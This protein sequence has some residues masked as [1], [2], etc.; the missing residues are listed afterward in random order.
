MYSQSIITKLRKLE[1]QKKLKQRQAIIEY[2]LKGGET[3]P[4]DPNASC[5]GEIDDEI[6]VL[7]VGH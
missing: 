2:M 4:R 5:D 6:T 1:R 7:K 3:D